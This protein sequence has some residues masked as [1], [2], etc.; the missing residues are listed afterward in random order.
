MDNLIQTARDDLSARQSELIADF[1]NR[2]SE[3]TGTIDNQ[4][5]RLDQAIA[6]YQ[7]QFSAAQEARA[8]AAEEARSTQQTSFDEAL[9]VI[10]E[11]A[12]TD[13]AARSDAAQAVIDHLN[14]LRED[15]ERTTNAIGMAGMAG[16]YKLDG[17]QQ[18]HNADLLRVI[19]IIGL[20][21]TAFV[22]F[23][24]LVTSH[25]N[26]QLDYKSF[27]AKLI[28]SATIGSIA[29]YAIVQS[30]HHRER[31]RQ[32]RQLQIELASIDAYL[33]LMSNEQR[34][35]I[36]AKL[37]EAWFGN[38]IQPLPISDAEGAVPIPVTQLLKMLEGRA[39]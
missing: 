28:V 1:G 9:R 23:L 12:D 16:G 11:K 13:F 37:A 20:A 27:S 7:A 5:A 4:K 17:D 6:E 25:S 8:V 14:T 30:A 15:A 31:E 39:K 18:K 26:G 29:A 35:E 19:A 3:L 32:D 21:L 22:A 10:N 34:N 24:A 33:A 2:I 38:P 36:K